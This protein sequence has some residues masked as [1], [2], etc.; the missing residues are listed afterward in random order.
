MSTKEA[1]A[2]ALGEKEAL[3]R[4]RNGLIAEAA[5]AFGSEDSFKR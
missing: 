2:D 5:E 4:M 1:P 3:R